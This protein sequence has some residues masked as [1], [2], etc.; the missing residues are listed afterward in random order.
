MGL[1]FW[2]PS[3]ACRRRTPRARSNRRGGVGKVSVRRIFRYHQVGTGPRRSPSACCEIFFKK[4]N[5]HSVGVSCGIPSYEGASGCHGAGCGG[6]DAGSGDEAGILIA[7][8]SRQPQ[9]KSSMRSNRVLL[10]FTRQRPFGDAQGTLRSQVCSCGSTQVAFHTK[11]AGTWSRQHTCNLR[12]R[13]LSVD[14][15]LSQ[16]LPKLPRSPGLR[17]GLAGPCRWGVA[18]AGGG[19]RGMYACCPALPNAA[20]RCNFSWAA[21]RLVEAAR[22]V[23]EQ[24]NTRKPCDLTQQAREA[25]IETSTALGSPLRNR[26]RGTGFQATHYWLRVTT[27]HIKKKAPSQFVA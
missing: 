9:N 23:T 15:I 13:W 14:S 10:L 1:F 12:R 19:R 4:R 2:Q 26:A 3:H 7:H 11:A 18:A 8:R 17:W 16:A 25:A 24:A 22:R 27:C 5:P 21:S 6:S 20:G